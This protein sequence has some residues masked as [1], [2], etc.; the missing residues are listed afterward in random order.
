MI[1]ASCHCG[2]VKLEVP[3]R[4]RTLTSCNCSICRRT[5]GLWA[6]YQGTEVRIVARPAAM[7]S[8]V[9]GDRMIRL[10]R[11]RRCGCVTH[12]VAA[13][14]PSGRMGVNTRNIDPEIMKGVRI[15]RFDG[16]NTW[17]FFD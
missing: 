8:Y 6:Y 3:R 16:A 15:R 17:K 14:N 4:P 9:W 13:K 12:W 7:S 11:C 5:G 1:E 2:S 10:M